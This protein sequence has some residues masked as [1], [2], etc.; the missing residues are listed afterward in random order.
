MELAIQ[1]YLRSGKTLEDLTNDYGVKNRRH[2]KYPNLVCLKYDMIN[3]PMGEE[4]VQECRGIILDEADD[5]KV[6]CMTFKKF[7]NL[8]EGHVEKQGFD[9]SNFRT[10]EKLDGSLVQ[11]YYYNNEWNYGTSGT[12]DAMGQVD[13]SGLLFRE[14]IKK[15]ILEMGYTI[16]D[17]EYKHDPGCFYAY[18]LMAPENQIVVFHPN[19]KLVLTAIRKSWDLKEYNVHWDSIDVP[20]VGYWDGISLDAVKVNAQNLNGREAEGY[21]LVDMNFNR[22]KLKNDTYVLLG[23]SKD[24]FQKSNKACLEIVVSE[25]EDDVLPLLPD[26]VKEKILKIKD[27]VRILASEIDESYNSIKDL[28]TDK[29]FGLATKNVKHGGVMFHIRKGYGDIKTGRDWIKWQCT[30]EKT[31]QVSASKRLMEMLKIKEEVTKEE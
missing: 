13:D 10:M 9:F 18:E 3:S 15:A 7:F 6:V 19:R 28:E 11:M 12:P 1:K 23:R 25:K 24:T 14:L 30:D 8:G 29:E 17:W 22:C 16:E 5:W 21:V 20:K 2:S 31:G 26:F 4:I 27:K